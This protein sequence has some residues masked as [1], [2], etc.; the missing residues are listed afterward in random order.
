MELLAS[1]RDTLAAAA[2]AP[3]GGAGSAALAVGFNVSLLLGTNADEGSEFIDLKYDA[4][5]E[6]YDAYMHE[7]MPPVTTAA[8]A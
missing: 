5:P 4:T 7:L 3:A 1:P 8:V 2:A 6:E